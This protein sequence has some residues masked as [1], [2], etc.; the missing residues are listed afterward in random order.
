MKL[1]IR[2]ST[3][4]DTA[5][6]YRII[7]FEIRLRDKTY[8]I[9]LLLLRFVPFE[10]CLGRGRKGIGKMSKSEAKPYDMN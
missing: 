7:S 9:L 4:I 10:A 3:G 6:L 2:Q 1:K 5:Y 8:M